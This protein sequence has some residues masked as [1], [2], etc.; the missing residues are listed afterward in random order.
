MIS[1][2]GHALES[3]MGIITL[4]DTIFSTPILL[5]GL[6]LLVTLPIL[7]VL[8]Q[9]RKRDHIVPIDP[10]LAE[11]ALSSPPDGASPSH[12]MDSG[13]TMAK[14]LNNSKAIS[15][16]I[17]VI[18]AI[19]LYGYFASG[20][21]FDVNII[22][23]IILFAGVVLLGTPARYVEMLNEGVKTVGGVILQYPFYAGLMAIM[24]STGLVDSISRVFVNISTT[25]T[26][27]LWGIISSFLINFFAPSA[28][29]HWVVQGPFMIE[30]A[31]SLGTPLNQTAM[32]VMLGNAWN[33]LVQP[34]WLLP[35]LALSRLHLKDIMGYTVIHMVW[36]GAVYIAALM[37]WARIG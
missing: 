30:A 26:L 32:A 17:G 31:H 16:A 7:N 21:G 13:N 11:K 20:K 1:T 6:A 29:G 25:H 12:T 22:N 18:A 34:F 15:L 5:T 2:K 14:R 37:I 4:R 9:P 8:M 28:G 3:K 10:S 19:Y 24:A 33:D 27:T 35:A 36:V 23:F